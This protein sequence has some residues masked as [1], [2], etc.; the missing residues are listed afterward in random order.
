MH[1]GAPAEVLRLIFN[2]CPNDLHRIRQ[3]LTVVDHL[4]LHGKC[5]EDYLHYLRHTSSTHTIQAYARVSARWFAH[6]SRINHSWTDF[7][8]TTQEDFLV[9]FRAGTAPG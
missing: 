7:L 9:W 3:D 2:V 1:G 6:L 5:N 8:T 4:G